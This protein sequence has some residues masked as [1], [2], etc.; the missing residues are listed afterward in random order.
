MTGAH[1]LQ[2]TFVTALAAQYRAPGGPWD[3][4]SLD[5][6]L[7]GAA[8]RA[9]G[10]VL[11]VDGDT[12]VTGAE[13]LARVE[14][15]ASTLRERGVGAGDAVAWQLGNSVE[16]VVALRACWRVGAV[17]V[18]L[19]A[20]FTAAE[21][22]RA[23]ERVH[24]A[25]VLSAGDLAFDRDAPRRPPIGVASGAAA[26]PQRGDAL[27]ALMFTSGSSGPPKGVLH[28]YDTVA[29]KARLMAT[30]HELTND[31]C[32]LMP[33]PLAHV[34][35]LLNGVTLPG[36]VPFKCVLMAR[37]NPDV[38]LELV[39]RERV[40]YMVGP[41]TFFVAMMGSPGFS[42]E[43]VE[44][45]RLVSSGGA[46][47][48]DAF[49]AEAS[50]RLGCVVK[51]T[52]GSTEAPSVATALPGAPNDA[53]RVIA[54]CELR[55]DDH[56]ELLIRGPEL[57]AGYL[58]APDTERAFTADGWY[59]SNDLAAIDDDGRLAILGRAD[60]VIIRGGE[61][62]SATEVVS[63]IERHPS[64]RQ[65]AVVGVADELM[66]ERACAFVVADGP[67]DLDECARWCAV[68]GLARYKTPE[69]VLRLDVL[70]VLATGKPDRNALRALATG[71]GTTSITTS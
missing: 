44:S 57:C 8:E 53:P 67:F 62:I 6:M 33:A 40:T 35:G 14:V 13:L 48:S 7:T 36:V 24:P 32:V 3:Q 59:R 39:E 54:P 29:Y 41:P 55:I 31:D 17:A 43:R 34:S 45:L 2:P 61:N 15:A 37:W 5:E 64:V 20:A 18:P 23:L 49:V 12:R 22:E 1:R 19:H 52:Y 60:D 38:A 56:G 26:A 46:G 11:V 66:G 9:A 70:P 51:R 47:V 25:L 4:P 71:D 63:V 68:E 21:V 65:C 27:A 69:R 28:T 50:E 10:T 16:A 58:D 30:V 42:T